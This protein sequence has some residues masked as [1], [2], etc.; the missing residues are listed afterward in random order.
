LIGFQNGPP[1]DLFGELALFDPGP[2]AATAVVI[3]DAIVA[4]S[5]GLDLQELAA[6]LTSVALSLLRV[7]GR[8]LRRSEAMLADRVFM[9]VPGRRC[10]P[11][12]VARG[13]LRH[14]RAGELRVSH[15]LTQ[16]ELAQLIGAS[17]EATNR[18]LAQFVACGW[19]CVKRRSVIIFGRQALANPGRRTRHYST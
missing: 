12:A 9:D 15:D 16:R 13:A 2:W 10:C 4:R 11:A 5:R 1:A 17:R 7:L 6:L 19:L 18:T 3:S 8:R 14:G